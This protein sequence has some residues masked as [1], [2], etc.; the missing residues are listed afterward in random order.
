[1]GTT[2]WAFPEESRRLS[3]KEGRAPWFIE[4]LSETDESVGVEG[5]VGGKQV[6]CETASRSCGIGSGG[7][8]Q[9]CE[10]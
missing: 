4:L 8:A 10:R 7:G 2:D 9:I 5:H 1:M 6:G 3:I